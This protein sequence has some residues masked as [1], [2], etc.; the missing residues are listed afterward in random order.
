MTVAWSIRPEQRSKGGA[1]RRHLGAAGFAQ[2]YERRGRWQLRWRWRHET[3]WTY[4]ATM[5]PEMAKAWL[6]A[7]RAALAEGNEPPE[8]PAAVAPQQVPRASKKIDLDAERCDVCGLLKP[9]SPCIPEIRRNLRSAR[10]G[11]P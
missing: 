1:W 7:A 3:S 2:S 6:A 9:C 11:E 4:G 10:R 8:P 5:S